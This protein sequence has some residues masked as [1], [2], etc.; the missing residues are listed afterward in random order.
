[1]TILIIIITGL[2]SYSAFKRPELFYK[3]C[4]T[5]YQVV[6]RKQWHRVITHAFVHANWEHLAVNMLVLFSFGEALSHYFEIYFS[7][8]PILLFLSLYFGGVIISSI[9]TL[10]REKDNF[11][12]NAVGASGAVSAVTFA[13]IFFDP[14]NK[15]YFFGILPIPGI[16]FGVLY[17]G[18]SYYMSKRNVDNIGHDAHFWGA[19]FGFAFPLLVRPELIHHF[20]NQLFR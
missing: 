15:I 10:I 19:V 12:Y 4:F 17:L 9:F 8:N 3:L 18:Y 16:L 2:I 1:M 14:L 13:C 11:H 20:F 7:H 5:P 6:H